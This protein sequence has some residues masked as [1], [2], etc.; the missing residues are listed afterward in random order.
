[1]RNLPLFSTDVTLHMPNGVDWTID[2][3]RARLVE[4]VAVRQ[5]TASQASLALSQRR[6][7]LAGG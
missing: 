5:G 1:M 7:A 3:A 4:Q 2:R 6:N